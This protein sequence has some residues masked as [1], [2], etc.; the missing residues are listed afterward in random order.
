MSFLELGILQCI[1][2]IFACC[3]VE[4]THEIPLQAR[5]RLGRPYV[6]PDKYIIRMTDA[7]LGVERPKGFLFVKLI[8]AENV[9]KMDLLSKSDPYVKYVSLFTPDGGPV[10]AAGQV[11]PNLGTA[12]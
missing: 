2:L 5:W 11:F 10:L 3:G 9:P 1:C 7:E 4:L 6:L 12:S 8:E